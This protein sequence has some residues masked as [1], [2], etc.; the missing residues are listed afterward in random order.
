MVLRV[1]KARQFVT[2]ASCASPGANY[3]GGQTFT[4]GPTKP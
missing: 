1:S 3:F 4:G 2:S